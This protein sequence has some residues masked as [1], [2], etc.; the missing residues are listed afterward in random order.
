MLIKLVKGELYVGYKEPLVMALQ[1]NRVINETPTIE[2]QF[3]SHGAQFEHDDTS[4]KLLVIT[5]GMTVF[6]TLDTKGRS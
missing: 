4:F 2:G 1:S 3:D 6:A 5:N